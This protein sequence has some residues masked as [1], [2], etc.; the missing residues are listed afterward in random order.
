MDT[1]RSEWVLSKQGESKE[2]QYDAPAWD[3]S[4]VIPPAGGNLTFL[5]TC[6]AN[7]G[8]LQIMAMGGDKEFGEGFYTTGSDTETP[9]KIIAGEWFQKKQK[10]YDWH[11]IAFSIPSDLLLRKLCGKGNEAIHADLQFF[12]THSTGY[13]SGKKDPDAGDMERINRINR[14]GR[15]LIFPHN[16]QTKVAFDTGTETKSWIEYTADKLG[17]GP[18]RLVIGPQQPEYMLEYRQY[19]WTSGY[20]IFLINSCIRFYRYRNYQIKNR[21]RI[22]LNGS[23]PKDHPQ[24]DENGNKVKM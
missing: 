13:P 14:L 11:V 24:V 19:A 2:K 10:R 8:G 5:H 7:L 12:L 21:C 4:L 20:G 9:Y 23:W 15:V 22:S 1:Y 17:G 18:Y 16:K 3:V 6:T